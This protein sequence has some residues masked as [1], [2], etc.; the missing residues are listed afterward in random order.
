MND[1]DDDPSGGKNFNYSLWLNEFTKKQNGLA[2]HQSQ[3]SDDGQFRKKSADLADLS[4]SEDEDG[5]YNIFKLIKGKQPEGKLQRFL[6][7]PSEPANPE[8]DENHSGFTAVGRGGR[9]LSDDGVGDSATVPV[10]L[11]SQ[12][13]PRRTLTDVKGADVPEGQMLDRINELDPDRGN[14]DGA[15]AAPGLDP[16]YVKEAKRGALSRFFS[17]TLQSKKEERGFG[18]K[19]KG[20][21]SGLGSFGVWALT[22]LQTG[23]IGMGYRAKKNYHRWR[24]GSNQRKA[25]LA[26]RQKDDTAARRAQIKVQM[27]DHKAFMARK[28]QLR[29]GEHSSGYDWRKRL[30]HRW[31][32]PAESQAISAHGG[33]GGD[34]RD[35]RDA[36]ESVDDER[37]PGGRFNREQLAR[38]KEALAKQRELARA[39]ARG[40]SADQV[41][42]LQAESQAAVD[43]AG[44]ANA[45]NPVVKRGTNR[46][47]SRQSNIRGGDAAFALVNQQ[48]D[49]NPQMEEIKE[50]EEQSEQEEPLKD[51]GNAH[52]RSQSEELDEAYA[53][54]GQG[55]YDIFGSETSLEEDE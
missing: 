39:Q 6:R 2:N 10:G 38:T 42:Q 53:K 27:H 8:R 54:A 5:G 29:I 51:T 36:I 1:L 31:L 35:A 11:G 12:S 17:P 41:A 52:P 46:Q 13:A 50:E 9:L 16:K 20:F 3:A 14:E 49:K 21:F 4:D 48:I 37:R 47:N 55:G 23:A 40:A 43:Q 26:T 28:E 7:P 25:E 19:V 30:G 22:G 33:P 18:D 34:W 45:E 24:R 32:T 44:V 15:A